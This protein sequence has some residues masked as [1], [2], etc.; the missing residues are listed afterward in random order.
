MLEEEGVSS[1]EGA[2]LQEQKEE[3]LASKAEL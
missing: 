3:A 1:L 2:V